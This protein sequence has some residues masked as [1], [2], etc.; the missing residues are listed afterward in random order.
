MVHAILPTL[1]RLAPVGDHARES[2][3]AL[4]DYHRWYLLELGALYPDEPGA[5]ASRRLLADS[6]VPE[7]DQGFMAVHDLL[8]DP[9]GRPD[10][11]LD[12]LYPAY[13][14]TGTGQVFLRSGW[15]AG[16]T[17]LRLG[18]GPYTESH[19]HHDQ[20]DLFVYRGGHLAYDANVDSHSGIHQEEEAHN[21]VRLEVDG[22][23]LR[24]VEG[25]TSVPLALH[26]DDTMTHVAADTAPAYD[27]AEGL[28]ELVREVVWIKPGVVVVL[29]RV[30]LTG[31]S[32]RKVFQ[33]SVPVS[34]SVADDRVTVDGDGATLDLLPIRPA[35]AVPDVMAWPDD[36]PDYLAGHRVEIVHATAGASLLLHVLSLDG[37]VTA[38]QAVD[39]AEAVGVTLTLA[40]GRTATV[41]FARTGTGGAV[42][43]TGGGAPDCA[44]TLEPGVATLPLTW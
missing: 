25:T 13:H 2:T 24:Q 1:D 10:A 34:P 6:T 14:G 32:V 43:L 18:V 36:D 4:F 33:L 27:G 15:D 22:A 20:G 23:V 19:A 8:Y 26:D 37:A 40:D 38:I 3:A 44:A 5:L 12:T 11:S 28:S 31:G 7:M 16:A 35:G 21:L 30:T 29:D 17:Y 41:T 9:T 42:D 39:E